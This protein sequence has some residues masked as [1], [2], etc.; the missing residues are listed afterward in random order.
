MPC[1]IGRE[2]KV[3]SPCLA[4]RLSSAAPALGSRRHWDSKASLATLAGTMVSRYT[5]T[6][7]PPWESRGGVAS[8]SEALGRHGLVGPRKDMAQGPACAVEVLFFLSLLIDVSLD[9]ESAKHC[10]LPRGMGGVPWKLR[11]AP[12]HMVCLSLEK[13]P[14]TSCSRRFSASAPGAAA[15]GKLDRGRS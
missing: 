2:P 12:F 7:L 14:P 3:R 5:P 11:A 1:D 9:I 6:P 8:E 4:A 13:L 15:W 10:P